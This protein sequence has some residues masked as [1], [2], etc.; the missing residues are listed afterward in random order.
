V[1]RTDKENRG[2][3]DNV[4]EMREIGNE[5]HGRSSLLSRN[6]LDKGQQKMGGPA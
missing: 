4:E 2:N 3:G 5:V 6:R 1:D